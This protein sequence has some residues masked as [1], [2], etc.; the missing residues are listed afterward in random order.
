ML[1]HDSLVSVLLS[2]Q[3]LQQSKRERG[4]TNGN[5]LLRILQELLESHGERWTKDLN[6]DVPHSCQRH[7]DLVLLG[8]TCFSLPVWKKTGIVPQISSLVLV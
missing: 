2:L 1:H 7:G 4:R 8:D 6:E 3:A 5:K